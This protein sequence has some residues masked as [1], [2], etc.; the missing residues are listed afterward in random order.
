M[1][2]YSR[3]P[4]LVGS[5]CGLWWSMLWCPSPAPPFSRSTSAS[6]RISSFGISSIVNADA[7]DAN[8]DRDPWNDSRNVWLRRRRSLGIGLGVQT[9]ISGVNLENAKSFISKS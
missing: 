1:V 2:N 8:S 5:L 9:T 6:S 7:C 3:S 4:L